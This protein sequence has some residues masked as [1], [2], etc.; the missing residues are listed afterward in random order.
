MIRAPIEASVR[1]TRTILASITA[2]TLEIS[3]GATSV[4]LCS[5]WRP[6]DTSDLLTLENKALFVC[7]RL[8]KVFRLLFWQTSTTFVDQGE[9]NREYKSIL[10]FLRFWGD[11]SRPTWSH[12]ISARPIKKKQLIYFSLGWGWYGRINQTFLIA[13]KPHPKFGNSNFGEKVWKEIKI[14]HKWSLER[15]VL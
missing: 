5:V 9:K 12:H 11:K 14:N 15:N 6:V 2:I 10:T 13:D 3:E 1:A 4:V 8:C 7:N